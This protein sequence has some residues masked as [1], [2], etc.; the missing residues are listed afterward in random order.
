MF[1]LRCRSSRFPRSCAVRALNAGLATVVPEATP[2]SAST[3]APPSTTTATTTK[4]TVTTSGRTS[5]SAR[6]RKLA[7][8]SGTGSSSGQPATTTKKW[9]RALPR[10][11]IPAYDLALGVLEEDSKT[12]KAEVLGRRKAIEGRMQVLEKLQA[13]LAG[14]GGEGG[15]EGAKVREEL[16][17]VRAE[18][19]A[20]L[21]KADVVE[22]QSEVNLP[23]VRWA[24]NNAMGE[25]FFFFFC[26]MDELEY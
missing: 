12:L 24:V 3:S 5:L 18:L 22:A 7:A 6:R 21:E 2:S 20:L 15:E 13:K 8:L 19:E 10:H 14:N 23:P 16:E 11:V 9:N 1:A 4:T 17:K 25:L 26:W